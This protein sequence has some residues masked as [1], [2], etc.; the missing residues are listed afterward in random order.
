M[1]KVFS[2]LFSGI[3]LLSAAAVGYYM[4]KTYPER[5]SRSKSCD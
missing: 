4:W 3:G 2:V 1:R 5:F